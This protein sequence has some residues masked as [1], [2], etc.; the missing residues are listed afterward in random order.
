VLLLVWGA[1]TGVQIHRA[2]VV[3]R[4]DSAST[5][6]YFALVMTTVVAAL[7]L[8]RDAWSRSAGGQSVRRP[9]VGGLVLVL[10]IGVTLAMRLIE[11]CA[12]PGIAP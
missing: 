7:W 10:C 8:A 3:C 9:D 1:I 6:L 12:G 4:S 11:V 2:A 5:H